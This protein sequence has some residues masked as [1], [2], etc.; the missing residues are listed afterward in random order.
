MKCHGILAIV[1]ALGGLLGNAA[2][3]SETEQIRLG[4]KAIEQAFYGSGATFT[5]RYVGGVSI[6]HAKTNTMAVEGCTAA[7]THITLE[8]ES[9][10]GL[11]PQT[12]MRGHKISGSFRFDQLT[13]LTEQTVGTNGYLIELSFQG[14]ADDRP[15]FTV[16][17]A[18]GKPAGAP[19]EIGGAML[20]QMPI[21]TW[22]K[23]KASRDKA[24]LA[25]Q[26]QRR[27]CVE[28]A[29]GR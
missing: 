3:D 20:D 8:K 5:Y 12:T 23:D 4:A 21:T 19:I 9:S 16:G 24:L 11:D 29:R 27:L 22:F 7:L 1:A 25:L 28:A 17:Y 6:E 2:P 14:R 15:L 18:G 13:A 10:D 26:N